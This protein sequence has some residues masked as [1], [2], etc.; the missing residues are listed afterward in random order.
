MAI[1]TRGRVDGLQRKGL[2]PDIFTYSSVLDTLASDARLWARDLEA[3]GFR[4]RDLR[5]RVYDL[6]RGLRSRA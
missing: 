2:E 4:V 5:F 3:E 1:I 6:G